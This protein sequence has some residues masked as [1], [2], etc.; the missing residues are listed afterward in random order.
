MKG[1]NV[2]SYNDS[3]CKEFSN[4]CGTVWSLFQYKI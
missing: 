1:E 2:L 3:T 4:R